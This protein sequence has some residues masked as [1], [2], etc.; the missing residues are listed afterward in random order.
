MAKSLSVDLRR[1]VVDAVEAGSSC[2]GT[3][4]DLSHIVSGDG[5][6]ISLGFC[7]A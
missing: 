5:G 7:H 4:Q 3:V 2:R 6:S 1:R